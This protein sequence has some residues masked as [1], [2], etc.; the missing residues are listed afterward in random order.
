MAECGLQSPG[1]SPHLKFASNS[2]F[3]RPLSPDA[4]SPVSS[5]TLTSKWPE[6]GPCRIRNSAADAAKG[7]KAITKSRSVNRRTNVANRIIPTAPR[8]RT[9][10][11]PST[12]AI[13]LTMYRS[14][15]TPVLKRNARK[16]RQ[17]LPLRAVSANSRSQRNDGYGADPGHSRGSPEGALSARSGH[18]GNKRLGLTPVRWSPPQARSLG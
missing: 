18:D 10:I 8:E 12:I 13:R 17:L 6:Y 1:P 3:N 7:T 9:V 4:M 2:A 5:I 15:A 11:S 16:F 14:R